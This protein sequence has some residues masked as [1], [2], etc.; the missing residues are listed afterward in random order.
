MTLPISYL[1]HCMKESLKC[2]TNSLLSIIIHDS[3]SSSWQANIKCNRE[4]D[5]NYSGCLTLPVHEIAH[6]SLPWKLSSVILSTGEHEQ[7]ANYLGSAH[8]ELESKYNYNM[9]IEQEI[10]MLFNKARLILCVPYSSHRICPYL[11]VSFHRILNR[12]G[13]QRLKK[14]ETLGCKFLICLTPLCLQHLACIPQ[15]L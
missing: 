9:P 13:R 10:R 12:Y 8:Q 14:Q 3:S 4:T 6:T 5:F 7:G 2:L 11:F 1:G 15:M